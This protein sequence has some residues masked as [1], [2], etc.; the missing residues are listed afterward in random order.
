MM[1]SVL[2]WRT[3]LWN[4]SSKRKNVQQKYKRAINR[5]RGVA[6]DNERFIIKNNI[7]KSVKYRKKFATEVSKSN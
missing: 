6:Y 5:F 2:L 4:L 1:M 3:V 7:V